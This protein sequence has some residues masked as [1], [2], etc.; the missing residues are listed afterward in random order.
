M[1]LAIHSPARLIRIRHLQNFCRLFDKETIN[2]SLICAAFKAI[3]PE[4]WKTINKHFAHCMQQEKKID[5]E[6][7]RTDTTVVET[8]GVFSGR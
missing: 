5:V 7:I 2:H 3:T 6:I 8:E 4:T 1:R